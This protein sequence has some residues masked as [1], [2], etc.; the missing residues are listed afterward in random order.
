MRLKTFYYGNQNQE[1]SH[2]EKRG[3]QIKG[4]D[5]EKRCKAVQLP[6][7]NAGDGFVWRQAV[8]VRLGGRPSACKYRKQADTHPEGTIIEI[9]FAPLALATARTA[10]GIP[11]FA[12]ISPYDMVWPQHFRLACDWR[13]HETLLTLR[14]VAGSRTNLLLTVPCTHNHGHRLAKG[15]KP[16][17]YEAHH[18]HRGCRRALDK[19]CYALRFDGLRLG[20]DFLPCRDA[21]HHDNPVVGSHVRHR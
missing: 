20:S 9:G 21:G 12:A 18:H 19:G 8:Y 3:S 15:H 16:G 14:A 13:F 1:G 4:R 2:F 5:P 11:I 10:S 7:R 17:I 6:L